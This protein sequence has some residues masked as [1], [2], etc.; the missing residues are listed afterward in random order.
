MDAR[1]RVVRNLLALLLN[2]EDRHLH[3]RMI[4]TTEADEL[5]SAATPVAPPLISVV[6]CTRNRPDTIERAIVSVAEQAYPT[7]EVLIVDQSSDDTTL[8]VVSRLKA[9]YP[10]VRYLRLLE[11]GLSGAYNAGIQASL[12][13]VLAF[14][15]DDCVASPEWLENISRAFSSE[16]DVEILYGQVLLPEELSARENVDGVTPMLP[17]AHRQRM[18]AREGFRVFGMGANF[19]ARRT[20]FERLGGFDEVLGG[21]GPLKSSQDFDF[22]YRVFRGGGTILLEPNV[23]VYH[24]GFRTHTQW[25]ATLSA[26]GTGDGGFYTKHLRAGDWYAGWLLASGFFR[27]TAREVKSLIRRGPAAAQWAY[28]HGV[29]T[30]I[31]ASLKYGV[32]RQRRLYYVR[33]HADVAS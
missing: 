21:G 19:A 25:P 29:L 2:N 32:D 17:I 16:P 12:N 9:L 20:A 28:P 8:C 10:Q 15:D 5:P 30:G 24:Y 18:N 11:P 13:E 6:I 27:A 31:R 7:F 14:T 3:Q 22:M 33:R 23:V 4:A 1:R 26:Y